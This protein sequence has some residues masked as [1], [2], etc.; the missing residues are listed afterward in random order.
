MR[1]KLTYEELKERSEQRFQRTLSDKEIAEIAIEQ[2]NDSVEHE[3][4]LEE[5]LSASE[6]DLS[7]Y[8]ASYRWIEGLSDFERKVSERI[9]EVL[10]VPCSRCM[11]T[12]TKRE[13]S[14]PTMDIIIEGHP[15]TEGS[16]SE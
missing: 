7:D 11:V 16:V 13:D 1:E 2:L 5:Q 9:H 14:V 6:E 12:F 15:L 10:S 3:M 4:D 8:K